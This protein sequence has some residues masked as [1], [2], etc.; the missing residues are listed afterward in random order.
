MNLS[1][2]TASPAAPPP[3]ALRAGEAAQTGEFSSVLS[4]Q[5]GQVRERGAAPA[6]ATRQAAQAGATEEPDAPVPD[7]TLALLAAGAVLPLMMARTE[8]PGEPGAASARGA[9]TQGAVQAAAP[10]N[11]ASNA[12][13]AI[14]ADAQ[15]LISTAEAAAQRGTAQEALAAD[16]QALSTLS[17]SAEAIALAPAETSGAA[18]S[19][20]RPLAALAPAASAAQI[21]AARSSGAKADAA[22]AAFTQIATAIRLN[23]Q[24]TTLSATSAIDSRSIQD[25]ANAVAGSAQMQSSATLLST[26]ASGSPAVATPLA[27]PA[28]A[29]DFSRQFVSMTQSRDLSQ[30]HTIELRLDPPSL[31]PVRITLHISDSI[32]QAAFVSP[33]AVVRQAI[34][35]ALPQLQQQLAEAGLSLGQASVND[36]QPGQQG[37]E[38]PSSQGSPQNRSVFSLDGGGVPATNAAPPSQRQA[39]RSPNALVDTFA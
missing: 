23:T 8:L 2:V 35:N 16:R 21:A 34:E 19:P 30:P 14:L 29:A 32:A 3:D 39:L 24:P 13:Q 27:N 11:P 22:Q 26:P 1:P 33:H 7:E 38:Q 9:R 10:S 4:Q 20:T 18:S 28:W 6:H 12:A 17:R 37:F 25:A 15:A 5:Q 36:Q 31:G